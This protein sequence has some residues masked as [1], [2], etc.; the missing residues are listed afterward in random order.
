M[1]LFAG[2]TV[3][4]ELQVQNPPYV[5]LAADPANRWSVDYVSAGHDT[6]AYD[7]SVAVPSPAPTPDAPARAA[8]SRRTPL[9]GI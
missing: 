2:Q 6:A 5:F 9:R 8:A 7:A 1:A 3:F 4:M